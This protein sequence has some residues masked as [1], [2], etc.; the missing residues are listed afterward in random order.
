[1]PIISNFPTG[2]DGSAY[3]ICSTKS[4]VSAKTVS[5]SGFKLVT[6]SSVKVKFINGNTAENPTLNV[7]STGEKQITYLGAPISKTVIKEHGVYEF[8]FDGT[9]WDFVGSIDNDDSTLLNNAALTGVP[10]A[11]TASDGTSTTQIATTA[12][13]QNAFAKHKFE[14]NITDD[15]NGNVTILSD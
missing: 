8:L 9:N 12:F 7:N 5:Y 13:V 6:G 11:P 10:T 15:D 2:I 1:M 14:L 3:G 4:N